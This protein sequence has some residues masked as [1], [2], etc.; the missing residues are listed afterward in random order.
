MRERKEVME[1][2]TD[3]GECSGRMGELLLDAVASDSGSAVAVTG[4]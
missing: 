3:G 2:W 4:P 1:G